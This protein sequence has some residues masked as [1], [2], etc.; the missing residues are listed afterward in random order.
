MG[1]LGAPCPFTSPRYLEEG[2]AALPCLGCRVKEQEQSLVRQWRRTEGHR[3]GRDRQEGRGREDTDKGE[4]GAKQ[5]GSLKVRGKPWKA[6]RLQSSLCACAKCLSLAPAC[7]YT[8]NIRGQSFFAGGLAW[9]WLLKEHP[10]H[11][12]SF[13]LHT[14]GCC[15]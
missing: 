3:Q 6:S 11:L 12:V 2:E 5:P 10:S 13:L 8:P 1:N 7:P 14:R 15:G 4:Q 9:P